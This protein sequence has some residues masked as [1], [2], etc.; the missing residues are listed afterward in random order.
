M[1]EASRVVDFAVGSETFQTWYTV[2]GDLKSGIR[3]LVLL[4]GGPGFSHE[5]MRCHAPLLEAKGIP[6]ILYD[7]LCCGNPTHLCEKPT[8]FWTVALF[9][10][11]LDNL[12]E[13]LGVREN[14]DLLGHSWGGIL[15]L[16]YVLD[17]QPSGLKHLV[18]VGAP[19]SI[20]VWNAECRKLLAQL[21]KDVRETIER[22][23]REGTTDSKEYKEAEHLFF[24]RHALSLDPPPI[25]VQ[26]TMAEVGKDDT[27]YRALFGYS[28]WDVR[29]NLG[30]WDVTDRLKEIKQPTLV[31]NGAQDE[32][33][34]ACAAPLFWEIPNG[35]WVQFAKSTHM[36][37]YEEPGRYLEVVSTFL[38]AHVG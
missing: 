35:K 30:S 9:V 29:G 3:P 33:T 21:P 27:V 16:A 26:R 17:R 12:L 22:C 24:V 14:F 10:S 25:G 36:A 20:S 13:K 8:D 4:H 37:F 18:L 2:S 6:L 34:D 32:T 19:P 7:Q 23:E 1:G 28:E 5:Y 15:A 38:T 31:I 11:E